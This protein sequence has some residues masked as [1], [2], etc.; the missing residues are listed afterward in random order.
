MN[1]FLFFI[2]YCA[3]IRFLPF[4][5]LLSIPFTCTLSWRLRGGGS[6]NGNNLLPP[7]APWQEVKGCFLPIPQSEIGSLL[8]RRERSLIASVPI[9]GQDS[10]S[11]S[12]SPSLAS[13][14]PTRNQDDETRKPFAPSDLLIGETNSLSSAARRHR[15]GGDGQASDC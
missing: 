13:F 11:P 5:T 1:Y 3:P 7:L 6:K 2:F 8:H 9:E 15:R 14:G 4:L 12:L 10:P